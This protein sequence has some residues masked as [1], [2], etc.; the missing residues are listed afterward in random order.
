MPS[1]KNAFGPV[2][3]SSRTVP[4]PTAVKVWESVQWPAVWKTRGA[5]SVPEQRRS[6]PGLPSS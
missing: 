2:R 4:Y 6:R 1:K 5:I 3:L